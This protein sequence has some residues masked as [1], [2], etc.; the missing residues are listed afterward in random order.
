MKMTKAEESVLTVALSEAV[1]D[2]KVASYGYIQL[3]K[4]WETR[5][6]GDLDEEFGRKL[7]SALDNGLSG[8]LQRELIVRLYKA[9]RSLPE[10]GETYAL[11][12]CDEF[13]DSISLARSLVADLKGLP[14]QYSLML[15]FCRSFSSL[16]E[17]KN[18][19]VR[20]SDQLS[21]V[22][23]DKLS[24]F[25][26]TH[27]NA[28]IDKHVSR[29][30]QG[31]SLDR[32]LPERGLFLL[33][34]GSGY[35]SSTFDPKLKE[36]F[37][38]QVRAFYGSCLSSGL[39]YDFY[40]ALSFERDDDLLV[41]ANLLHPD[42][43][44]LVFAGKADADISRVTNYTVTKEVREKIEAGQSLE[45][46]LQRAK[47][48]FE[49]EDTQRFIAASIWLL[50]AFLS[51]KP[52]DQVLESAI[53]IEVL[54][55]DR[56]ASDRVGLSKLMANR[57]AYSLGKTTKE[58][59]E[60]ADFFQRFYKVRS[61]IVHSGRFKLSE[62]DQDIVQRGRALAARLLSHEVRLSTS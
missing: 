32:T 17:W 46:T 44:E 18:I 11:R 42:G 27:K 22:S 33:W 6:Y 43:N 52:H 56:E 2:G 24:D 59:R 37:L 41:S 30:L 28:A 7:R 54:L 36:S 14:Q 45:V 34:R 20:I 50:R 19:Q 3:P 55:G 26:L 8:F 13:R 25:S 16:R 58:R 5:A 62:S 1:Q 39:L 57:C 49:S 15:P 60:M 35:I 10:S 48:I 29:T 61:D 9:G 38:D 23:S 40:L 4:D 53:A 47:K 31:E 21:I 51:S 12:D